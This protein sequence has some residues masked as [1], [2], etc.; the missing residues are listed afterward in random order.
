MKN[1]N[2]EERYFQEY[3]NSV[4]EGLNCFY[5]STEEKPRINSEEYNLQISNTLKKKYKSGEII[6]FKKG[7]GKK[8]N[9]FIFYFFAVE[10]TAFGAG[11][12]VAGAAVPSYFHS[13]ASGS[14][15]FGS[16]GFVP[17]KDN[18]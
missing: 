4:K 11:V 17:C 6:N 14:V 10:S 3:Y 13:L 9:I 15:G 12:S 2:K 1:L 5:T 7:K 18:T 8:F 16:L